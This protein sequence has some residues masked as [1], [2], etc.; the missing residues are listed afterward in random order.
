MNPRFEFSIH[1]TD[2]KAR[3]CRLDPRTGGRLV[4]LE[5]AR[6]VACTGAVPRALVNCMN[7]GNPEHPDVMWQFSEAI[8]GMSDA[9]ETAN[10]FD[11]RSPADGALDAD[12][13]GLTNAQEFIAGT[14]PRDP[15]S[16]GACLPSMRR[17]RRLDRVR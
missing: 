14:D 8:D 17:L 15:A 12:N 13:D 11:P 2:G 16:Y 1:A 7:F 9:W 10:N 3:F 6:N 5:A 4:V